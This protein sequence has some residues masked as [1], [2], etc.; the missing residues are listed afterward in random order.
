MAT[1]KKSVRFGTVRIALHEVVVDGSKPP[2]DGL[3]PLG[4]GPLMGT[5]ERSVEQHELERSQLGVQ[6]VDTDERRDAV[7]ADAAFLLAVER[8]NREILG[9]MEDAGGWAAHAIDGPRTEPKS[10][11]TAAPGDKRTGVAGGF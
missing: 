5:E 11:T 1:T 9:L 7:K 4:L 3:A 6:H 8:A 2:S 10:Y